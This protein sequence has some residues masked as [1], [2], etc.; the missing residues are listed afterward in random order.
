MG[1]AQCHKSKPLCFNFSSFSFSELAVYFFHL[2]ECPTSVFCFIC[3]I[4]VV[5]LPYYRH[6]WYAFYPK[7]RSSFLF[8]SGFWYCFSCCKGVAAAPGAAPQSNLACKESS[9]LVVG[10]QRRWSRILGLGAWSVVNW[11]GKRCWWNSCYRGGKEG[12]GEKLRRCFFNQI[13]EERGRW[14]PYSM[15]DIILN[16][17]R[18]LTRKNLEIS[19]LPPVQHCQ[20]CIYHSDRV[21]DKLRSRVLRRA[22]LRMGSQVRWGWHHNC[23]IEGMKVQDANLLNAT[24]LNLLNFACFSFFCLFQ[25]PCPRPPKSTP[26]LSKSRWSFRG[27]ERCVPRHGV[28]IEKQLSGRVG[29]L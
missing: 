11:T 7:K 12:K 10:C 22:A 1:P 19:C 3:F 16:I 21:G 27:D 25:V 14:F 20:W 26:K 24:L 9:S 18:Y 13:R 6:I 15:W 29:R 2:S 8:I 23:S 4:L 5:F 28:M 17:C